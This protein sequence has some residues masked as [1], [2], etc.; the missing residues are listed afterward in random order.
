MNE[1]MFR[2]RVR[3][4]MFLWLALGL[5]SLYSAV[6][7]LIKGQNKDAYLFLAFLFV[8]VLMIALNSRRSKMYMEKMAKEKQNRK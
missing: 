7:S 8:A 5:V 4:L 6:V 1:K 3:I 2:I